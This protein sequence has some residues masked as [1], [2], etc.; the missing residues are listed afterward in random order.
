MKYIAKLLL[1]FMLIT[2]IPWII[3]LYMISFLFKNNLSYI[4]Y[5]LIYPDWPLISYSSVI[6]ITTVTYQIFAFSLFLLLFCLFFTVFTPYLLSSKIRIF[7]ENKKLFLTFNFLSLTISYVIINLTYNQNKLSQ[8]LNLSVFFGSLITLIVLLVSFTFLNLLIGYFKEKKQ[9]DQIFESSEIKDNQ[10][11]DKL[12][13]WITTIITVLVILINITLTILYYLGDFK[14]YDYYYHKALLVSISENWSI[15][16]NPFYNNFIN[17]YPPGFHLIVVLIGKI[18]NISPI[19]IFNFRIFIPSLIGS[20]ACYLSLKCLNLDNDIRKLGVIFTISWLNGFTNFGGNMVFP[21]AVSLFF[22]V[23]MFYFRALK[24]RNLVNLIFGSIFFGL[25]FF[26]HFEVGFYGGLILGFYGLLIV[27]NNDLSTKFKVVYFVSLLISIIPVI[28]FLIPILTFV[29]L[30]PPFFVIIPPLVFRLYEKIKREIKRITVNHYLL[31]LIV[32]S[33]LIASFTI[34]VGFHGFGIESPILIGI[35]SP[36]G[37]VS[38]ILIPLVYIGLQNTSKYSKRMRYFVY[39]IFFIPYL[40]L[41]RIFLHGIVLTLNDK[42][43]VSFLDYIFL[44]FHSYSTIISLIGVTIFLALSFSYLK[45]SISKLNNYRRIKILFFLSFSFLMMGNQIAFFINSSKNAN[46]LSEDL[47]QQIEELKGIIPFN[48]TVASDPFTSYLISSIIGN[49]I[50]FSEHKT[51]NNLIYSLLIERRS[52]IIK[53]LTFDN[54]TISEIIL[55][56]YHSNI[57]ALW[58]QYPEELPTSVGTTSFNP[59]TDIRISVFQKSP[60]IL[61]NETE[62]FFIWYYPN[63]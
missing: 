47:Y 50:I 51:A 49:K 48:S 25:A 59:S 6:S 28:V 53:L 13:H 2:L 8:L 54:T 7:K 11:N 33:I 37:I 20:V 60:F 35:N 23:L 9:K 14:S 36:I 29:G 61:I 44:S 1:Y 17:T 16:R 56:K 43:E 21:I 34:Y 12:Y 24:K 62:S 4:I 52:D 22:L 45:N 63:L 32:F 38:S 18:F 57:I 31:L 26:I 55:R 42:V 41:L 40:S 10:S 19:K 58:K 5:K 30:L 15:W 27:K 3:T 46:Y 39:C